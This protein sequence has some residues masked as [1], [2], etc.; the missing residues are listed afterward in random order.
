MPCVKPRLIQ[1]CVTASKAFIKVDEIHRACLGVTMHAFVYVLVYVVHHICYCKIKVL[2]GRLLCCGPR[3]HLPP[4]TLEDS[5]LVSFCHVCF[6]C[7]LP[8]FTFTCFVVLGLAIIF[9]EICWIR[10]QGLLWMI[11]PSRQMLKRKGSWAVLMTWTRSW[12]AMS[13]LVASLY[14]MMGGCF[15]QLQ[16]LDGILHG[17]TSMDSQLVSLLDMDV[18]ISLSHT[19]RS[20]LF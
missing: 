6:H 11:W 3:K 18:T 12:T 2:W 16:V 7:L 19:S 10:S 9:V 1:Q 5:W 13:F 4:P 20:L 14:P 8:A 17:G 15:W